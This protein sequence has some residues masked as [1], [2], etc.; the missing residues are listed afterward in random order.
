MRR[1]KQLE[2]INDC[3]KNFIILVLRISNLTNKDFLLLLHGAALILDKVG[4][5]YSKEF[6]YKLKEN[7]KTK[8][9][10]DIG[11][12]KDYHCQEFTRGKVK[13]KTK[14]KSLGDPTMS[15]SF[16]KALI[17]SRNVLK[18]RHCAH[19]PYHPSRRVKR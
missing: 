12:H 9:G 19:T 11:Q 7:N 5:D 18:S 16:V 6:N 3:I 14:D 8:N 17:G 15:D 10:E 2:M 4:V 13:D 1:L